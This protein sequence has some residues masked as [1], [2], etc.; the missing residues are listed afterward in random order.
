MLAIADLAGEAWSKKAREVAVYI[1][2]RANRDDDLE[3]GGVRVLSLIR[4]AFCDSKKTK[5]PTFDLLEAINGSLEKKLNAIGLARIL[6]TFDIHS[7]SIRKEVGRGSPTPKGY[8][9]ADFSDA[10]KRYL[11]ASASDLPLAC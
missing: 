3:C 8:Q 7:K 5:M 11:P 1:S 9:L 6:K 10:F 4:N 2:N